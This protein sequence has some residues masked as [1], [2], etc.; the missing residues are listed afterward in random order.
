MRACF[1]VWTL[2]FDSP[3]LLLATLENG[4]KTES[5]GETLNIFH[6]K[7]YKIPPPS[8]SRIVRSVLLLVAS[9]FTADDRTR[10]SCYLREGVD[11]LT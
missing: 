2:A 11:A 1:F 5:E 4:V 9:L 6:P 10:S 7:I 3:I 8:I